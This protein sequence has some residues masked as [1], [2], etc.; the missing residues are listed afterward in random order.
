[1]KK[2]FQGL[3]FL[4][5]DK[6]LWSDAK[7]D[8]QTDTEDP[9]FKN[10][11]KMFLTKQKDKDDIW[12]VENEK[13][14]GPSGFFIRKTQSRCHKKKDGNFC[15]LMKVKLLKEAQS[16]SS[17][18][19]NI[20]IIQWFNGSVL[21]STKDIDNNGLLKVSSRLGKSKL[22]RDTVHLVML[23]EKNET[24]NS[25]VQWCH[26]AVLYGGRGFSLNKLLTAIMILGDPWKCNM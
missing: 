1:M 8:M 7:I 10:Q 15:S 25:R 12:L 20:C 4:W 11:E 22:N 24:K 6:T 16:Y 14:Y 18:W 23:P 21:R 17:K 9:E 13:D 19:F 26:K 2:W 3:Q 5:T